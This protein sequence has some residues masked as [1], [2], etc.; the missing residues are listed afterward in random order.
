M[1]NT[2]TPE[3]LKRLF[4][5]I[6][7][8]KRDENGDLVIY[9]AGE[10][11]CD[12]AK[13]IVLLRIEGL[14]LKSI[15]AEQGISLDRV[16]Q[17]LFKAMRSMHSAVFPFRKTMVDIQHRSLLLKI[18]ASMPKDYC[19]RLVELGDEIYGHLASQPIS[20]L[21]LST[22]AYNIL[23]KRSHKTAWDIVEA[24]DYLKTCYG[25]GAK[26]FEE[27]EWAIMNLL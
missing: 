21:G 16:R 9:R 1:A 10:S 24:E 23:A 8:S 6:V 4:Y 25:M 18:L 11:L 22:R 2:P 26:S 20:K 3:H 13:Q 27:I 5:G 19:K 15:A 17:I 7:D 14:T 12:R